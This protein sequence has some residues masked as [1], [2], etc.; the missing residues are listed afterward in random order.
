MARTHWKKPVPMTTDNA[1][2]HTPTEAQIRIP[3]HV[4]AGVAI[5][6]CLTLWA[7]VFDSRGA[8]KTPPA[9][10]ATVKPA[11]FVATAAPAA[12][13]TPALISAAFAPGEAKAARIPTGLPP[14]Y[15]DSRMP[16][17][18]GVEW[19]GAILWVEGDGSGLQD[20]APPTGRRAPPEPPQPAYAP[21]A[22][23]AAPA[24]TNHEKPHDETR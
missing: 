9:A 11:L 16:G 22:L 6:V 7:L 24:V 14:R 20:L 4:T 1:P 2:R 8:L 3:P 5:M 10:R 12:T 18:V 23:P 17:W 19:D 21:A 13:E 15:Q